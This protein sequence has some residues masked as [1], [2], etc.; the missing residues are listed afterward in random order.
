MQTHVERNGRPELDPV[1]EIIGTLLQL[2]LLGVLV[3]NVFP[4]S[5]SLT[6]VIPPLFRVLL[7]VL[8]MLVINRSGAAVLLVLFQASIFLQEPGGRTDRS[9]IDSA[10]AAGCLLS[11]LF[12]VG[13]YD[14]Y[15]R[16][17]NRAGWWLVLRLVGADR[18][19]DVPIVDILTA[20]LT[21]LVRL[22]GRILQCG[23]LIFVAGWVLNKIPSPR[24]ADLWMHNAADGQRM[25]APGPLILTGVFAVLV[26]LPE[27]FR[28]PVNTDQANVVLQT[29]LMSL[30][31]RDL[32]M[33][34]RKELKIRRQKYARRNQQEIAGPLRESAESSV[35][36][37]PGAIYS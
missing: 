18:A 21:F 19:T 8:L 24:H 30:L 28:R 32:R 25:L 2:T 9:V 26:L 36:K 14:R 20:A 3:T 1:I 7:F 22:S 33:I 12:L 16:V 10:I 34:A 23:V 31:Y 15:R 29:S 5:E 35:S 27:V 37:P 17:V 13:Q 11:V 4:G 6:I